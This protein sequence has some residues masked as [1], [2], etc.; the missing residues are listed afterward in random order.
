MDS[1]SEPFT[2]HVSADPLAKGRPRF[3]SGRVVTPKDTRAYEKLCAAMIRKGWGIRPV[4]DCAVK[5]ELDFRMQRPTGKKAAVSLWAYCK[6]MPDIDNLAKAVLDAGN[7][8]IWTDD[9]RICALTVRKIFVESNPG[10]TLRVFQL[11]GKW[12]EARAETVDMA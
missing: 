3:Y 1:F 5:V 10:F 6:P 7:E 12:D 8:I 4:L 11:S 2:L 9:V